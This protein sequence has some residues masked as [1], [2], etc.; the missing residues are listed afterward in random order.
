MIFPKGSPDRGW[1]IDALV[2]Y[3][4]HKLGKQSRS[5]IGNGSYDSGVDFIDFKTGKGNISAAYTFAVDVVE[6]KVD[7]ETGKVT[8]LDAV[9]AHDIGRALNPVLCAGQMD[10][11]WVQA[12][13]QLF[14]EELQRDKKDGHVLNPSFLDYKMPTSMDIPLKIK[15]IFVET[16]DPEGPFGAKEVGEGASVAVVPARGNESGKGSRTK[17]NPKRIVNKIDMLGRNERRGDIG[18]AYDDI[19]SFIEALSQTKEVKVNSFSSLVKSNSM[20]LKCRRG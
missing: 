10:G 9:G 2:R 5:I 20:L 13:G 15:H 1:K 14:F 19:R 11:A 16:I 12:E 8:I 17:I 3:A 7:P 4:Q 18:M 6:L